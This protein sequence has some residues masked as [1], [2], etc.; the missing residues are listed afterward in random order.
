M[1]SCLHFGLQTGFS[2]FSKLAE[3]SLY[4]ISLILPT[5]NH[6]A[7]QLLKVPSFS[8]ENSMFEARKKLIFFSKS[9]PKGDCL[10]KSCIISS[11]DLITGLVRCLNGKNMLDHQMFWLLSDIWMPG[12]L[13]WY[14]L[15]GWCNGLH[16]RAEL[17][18]FDLERT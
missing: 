5:T 17:Y 14:L 1:L 18:N 12:T 13:I 4:K 11:V 3:T 9:A 8:M 7:G 10:F 6:T 16:V 15:R 2:S